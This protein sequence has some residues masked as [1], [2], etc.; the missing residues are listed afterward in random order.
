MGYDRVT[1]C[2]L[3][4]DRVGCEGVG[5]EGEGCEGDAAVFLHACV[6]VQVKDPEKYGFN[7]KQM[8]AR[9]TD[10]YLHLDSEEL[11]YAVATDEVE[12]TG[13]VDACALCSLPCLS[14]PLSLPPLSLPLHSAR[15]AK[16]SLKLVLVCWIGTRSNQW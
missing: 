15:I 7:P 6:C 11:A 13:Q 3:G 9:L 12:C 10:I 16:N 2:S 14:L 4:G 5:C 1:V 8:L